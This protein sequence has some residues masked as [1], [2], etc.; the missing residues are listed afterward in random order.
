MGG[1]RPRCQGC[2]SGSPT[3]RRTSASAPGAR[4]SWRFTPLR[5]LRGRGC[6]GCTATR[7]LGD[8]KVSVVADAAPGVTAEL[9]QRGDPRVG[10]ACWPSSSWRR[11]S[12]CS[13]CRPSWGR[14][15]RLAPGS[16]A[17]PGAATGASTT[18]SIWPRSVRS[19]TGPA[20]AGATTTASWSRARPQRG[21]PIPEAESQQRYLHPPP[22][23]RVADRRSGKRGPGRA[24]GERL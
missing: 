20:T 18:S 2:M 5:R 3:T 22:G 15:R 10:I 17:C 19:A 16:T 23:R 14:V 24:T 21:T 6:A 1:R 9:A 12:G 7:P 11:G 4:R 13:M 8:D